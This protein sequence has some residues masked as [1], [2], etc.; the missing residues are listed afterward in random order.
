M[1][2]SQFLFVKQLV[3][4]SPD[5]RLSPVNNYSNMC[6]RFQYRREISIHKLVFFQIPN[7]TFLINFSDLL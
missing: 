2:Y 7:T 6:R 3:N 1:T 4:F 5:F